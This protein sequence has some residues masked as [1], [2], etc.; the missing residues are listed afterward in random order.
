MDILSK[1]RFLLWLS[2]VL[3]VLN[4]T[5]IAVF[6]I[7][8]VSLHVN[9]TRKEGG[10]VSN[11]SYFIKDELN[12]NDS[13][14]KIV[15]SLYKNYLSASNQIRE[16]IRINHDS[17]NSTIIDK[18]IKIDV[19]GKF[20]TLGSMKAQL[21]KLSYRFFEDLFNICNDD[22]KAKYRQLFKEISRMMAPAP[23]PKKK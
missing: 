11:V 17:I 20:D 10:K 18:S 7:F 21:D 16:F 5:T 9:D 3:A 2:I 6:W 1:N 23:K 14:S 22:Q 4:I 8:Y 12:F 15:D 19:E 13:Q